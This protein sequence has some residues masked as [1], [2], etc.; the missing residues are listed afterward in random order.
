MSLREKLAEEIFTGLWHDL[1]P[2]SERD[3]VFL[4]DENLELLDVAVKVASDEATVVGTWIQSGKIRRPTPEEL[5]SW[6]G[7]PTKGFRFVIVQPYVLIQD[8]GH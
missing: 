1:K 5:E 6:A 4:V 3:A 2:H 8:L 7:E